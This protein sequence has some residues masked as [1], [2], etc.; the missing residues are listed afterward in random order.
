MERLF[1]K[2]CMLIVVA[3]A[4]QMHGN[5]GCLEKERIALLAIK[6]FIINATFSYDERNRTVESW[7]V[8][9]V[10]NCCNWYQVECNTTTGRVMN[11]SLSGLLYD[12]TAILNF[13]LFQPLEQ[14]QILDLSQNYFEGWVDNRA[15]HLK[16]L[17]ILNLSYNRFNSSILP[18]LTSITS[19]TTLILSG[20]NFQDFNPTQGGGLGNLRNLEYLDMSFLVLDS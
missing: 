2:L 18:Y 17:K 11:L 20:N 15:H 5:K 7:V 9:R 14:L 4:L 6:P 13:S 19:L 1:T 3:L 10:S 8:D 12:S 16:Q